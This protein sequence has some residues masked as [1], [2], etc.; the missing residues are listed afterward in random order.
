MK[1][2]SQNQGSIDRLGLTDG[3]ATRLPTIPLP[4]GVVN[5][6]FSVVIGK[7]LLQSNNL[8]FERKI[9]NN[10]AFNFMDTACISICWFFFLN[11]FSKP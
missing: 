6:V 11:H 8:W 4:Q 1:Q 5:L 2:K 10:V 9:K 3:L 7:V